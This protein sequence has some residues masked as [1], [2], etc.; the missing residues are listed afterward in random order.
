VE[1]L[2]PA[3]GI[4]EAELIDFIG[5]DGP[6]IPHHPGHVAISLR[7]SPRKSVLTISLVLAVHLNACDRAGTYVGAKRQPVVVGEVVIQAQ[8]VKTCAFENRIVSRLW[9]QAQ[10]SVGKTVT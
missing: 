1:I 6:R 2:Q 4:L 8:R 7:G 3:A 10:E 5:A 9:H